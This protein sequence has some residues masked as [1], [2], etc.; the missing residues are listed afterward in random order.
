MKVASRQDKLHFSDYYT[1]TCPYMPHIYML[2]L[3]KLL[4]LATNGL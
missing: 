1:I 2:Q 3:I 4:P